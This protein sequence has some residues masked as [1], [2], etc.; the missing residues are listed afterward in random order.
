MK[1]KFEF[2]DTKIYYEDKLEE[3][4]IN[5]NPFISVFSKPNLDFLNKIYN[6]YLPDYKDAYKT[7]E[8]SINKQK[9]NLNNPANKPGNLPANGHDIYNYVARYGIANFHLQAVMKLD[10]R[11]DFDI[12]S[13]AVRLSV[14]AEPVLGC[15]FIETD[16]PY[17]KRLDNI[18]KIK[19][20]SFEKTDNMDEAVQQFLENPLDMDKDPMVKVKLIRSAQ[21][22]TLCIKIN[23]AC[24]DGTGTKEYIKLLSDIYTKLCHEDVNFVPKPGTRSR[25][26][27]D[28]LFTEL[29]I[30]NPEAAW[31]PGSE[32]TRATWLFPWKQVQTDIFHIAVCRLPNGQINKMKNYVKA[33]GATIN[34]LILTAYYRAMLTMGRPVYNEPMEIL[35]TIDLRRYLPDHKTE[36][37]RN[38]SGSEPTSILMKPNESFSETFYKVVTIM[39]E[40]KK[41]HAG[42]QSAIGLERIENLPWSE[43]LAYYK[44]ISLWPTYCCDKCAPVL[45]NL[46]FISKELIK[47]GDNVVIDAYI[48]PPVV[49]SPGFLLM[50]STY[51]GVLTL[52]AGYY[53]ASVLREDVEKLLNNIRE[54]LIKGCK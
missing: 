23:H 9:T 39:K 21:D 25:K 35:V 8:G 38:L 17:W 14:D 10:G 49:R 7:F 20:C 12:L 3:T 22:D 4:I 41:K 50:P 33:R 16:P 32:I 2:G 19:F 45:S 51:N 29:G 34:D 54:E 37:I 53:K 48:V 6:N 40:L 42:L 26:D 46:G 15:R 30:T 43:T 27:Q 47:F 18:D 28:R 11:L 44:M 1:I 24:C 13:K 31:I 5:N 36:E 52:S